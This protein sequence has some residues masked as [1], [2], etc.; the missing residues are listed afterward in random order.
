MT[1]QLG[2]L[3]FAPEQIGSENANPG[4]GET[5]V[6]GQ[7][8][9]TRGDDRTASGNSTIETSGAMAVR[10]VHSTGEQADGSMFHAGGQGLHSNSER[11]VA[12][13]V[14]RS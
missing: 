2:E 11:R 7:N 10:N 9:Y 5:V 8:D 13:A 6:S 14:C 4:S 12:T 1:G 3:T